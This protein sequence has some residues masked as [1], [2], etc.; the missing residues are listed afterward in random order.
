MKNTETKINLK[1]ST[2]LDR[3]AQ[4]F[5]KS[6]HM[7]D[8]LKIRYYPGQDC[9]KNCWEKTNDIFILTSA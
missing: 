8:A 5:L 3:N 4:L 2:N 6:V 7:T 9:I 1:T